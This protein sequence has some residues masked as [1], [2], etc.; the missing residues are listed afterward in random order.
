M[1][2]KYPKRL[3]E[4][5]S[6]PQVG[7]INNTCRMSILHKIKKALPEEYEIVKGDPVFASVFALYENGLGYSARLI[8]SIMCRQLVTKRRH[9]LWFVFGKK[10]LRFSMQEFHAVTGLKYSADFSHDSESWTDD[11]GFWSKLLKRG[12]IITIQNLMKTHLEAAPSWRKQEDRIRFVYV[13]VIA[14][15]VVAKDEKKA[16]PHSY[17][18]LVMDLEKVRTY[19][20][21][22]VAFD[23]LVSSIVEARKKLKNPISYILNG[24]SY[25]LQVWVMEAIPLIGQLMGEK[26]DTEITLS[27]ISNWKGAAK[28]SYDEL[29]LLEKSIGNKDVVYPCISSTGNFD[30]LESIE[31]L[32]GDEIEDCEVDNLEALIRSDYDFGDHIWESVEGYGVEA[33]NIEDV[34]VEQSQTVG[35]DNEVPV[36]E[37]SGEKQADIPEV[38]S[39]KKR[40]K[41]LVDHGAETQ[42]RMVLNQRAST[43][44]CSCGDDMKRFFKELID[45]SFKS[46]TET[47]G[48]RLLTLEKDVS[49][50]KALISRPAAVDPKPAAVDP[51]PPVVDPSPSRVKPKTLVRKK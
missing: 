43:S 34:G 16:I 28:V 18:K 24:F 25:A 5:G 45:S 50:I 14:G 26:I 27:R 20:W 37:E 38:S 36:G 44:H 1:E 7:Q 48:E 15:L 41:K 21:G 9:E 2:K 12:G 29:L 11:N 47:F 39:L 23:H 51:K 17:I 32:R 35:G 8:H 42:K 19:P 13:C 33:D 31:F 3:M 30:V 46:F 22:L 4:D 10:P 49:D 6:E 40:K